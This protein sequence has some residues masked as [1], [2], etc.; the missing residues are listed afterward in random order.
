MSG[1]LLADP[2]AVLA[3]LALVAAGCFW[4]ERATRWRLFAYVPPLAFIYLLPVV[5]TNVGV[6]PAKS[7][8]YDAIRELVLP[9]MLVLLLL[10]LDVAAA[11]RT[12]G[13]GLGVML[14]GSL[15]VVVGAAASAAVVGRWLGPTAWKSYGALAGSWVGGTGN[16][17]AVAGA[18]EADKELS[19]AV[20]AD[21]TIYLLWL[22]VLLSSKK[23]AAWFNRFSGVEPEYFERLEAAAAS[24]DVSH[25]RPTYRD[26]LSLFAVGLTAAAVC[27]SLAEVLSVRL[28]EG[29]LEVVDAKTIYILL[30][31]TAAIG[32]SFTPL[33]RIAGSRELSMALLFLFVARMGA[34]A[35]LEKLAD[36]A[37]PFV[38]G[39]V[40]WIF[41][42]GA[43]CL[44]GARL[45]RVDVATAAIASAAN[46]GGA[47]SAPIVAAHHNPQLVPASILM[48]LVG[49][50]VGNYCGLLVARICHA[51]LGASA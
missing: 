18:L 31:T 22:P 27:R 46:I 11:V 41:I 16:M 13:R 44:L 8:V 39:A 30:L 51:I 19:L 20:L 25:E 38:L 29:V 34:S 2:L 24:Y 36:Q 23:L 37:V 10:N 32:L 45:F 33:R 6:L 40:L 15:G 9:M 17:A 21:T 43:F 14:F 50:A 35:Q 42:H 47:A 49:Y 4:I 5:L 28:P 3:A 7:P 48:A 12:L 1:P 26:Y